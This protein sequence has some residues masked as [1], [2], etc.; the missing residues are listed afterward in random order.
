MH[1]VTP[2]NCE[3]QNARLSQIMQKVLQNFDKNFVNS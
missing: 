3:M 1:V 2:P